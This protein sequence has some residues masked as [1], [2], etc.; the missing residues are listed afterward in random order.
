MEEETEQEFNEEAE[1]LIVKLHQIG[2]K[3]TKNNK[4]LY[5]TY[6]FKGRYA[7]VFFKLD[8]LNKPYASMIGE[9]EF[10][11]IIKLTQENKEFAKDREQILEY[12]SP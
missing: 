7:C 6:F 12:Q 3:P 11:P 9:N 8:R 10:I 2:Y 5:K 1:K 4:A